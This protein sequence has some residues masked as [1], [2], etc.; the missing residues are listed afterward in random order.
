QFELST[1]AAGA[2]ATTSPTLAATPVPAALPT[3]L[4]IGN[5]NMERFFND[6][7]DGNGNTVILTSAAYQGRLN[8][9]SL[10]VRNVMRSPD[11]ITL[12][13]VEGPSPT[14]PQ[15]FPVPA[16]IV[17]KINGDAVAAGQQN[18]NYNWCEYPTNDISFIS[19]A[20]IYKQNRVT[21]LD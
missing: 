7:D 16:D 8:K 18:P 3:D 21:L 2:G 12:E 15:N 14:S 11:I 19:I 6:K 1:N 9:M 20:V 13:E 4:T 5:F 10:A 17:N